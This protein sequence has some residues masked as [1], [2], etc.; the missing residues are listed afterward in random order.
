VTIGCGVDLPEPVLLELPS[1]G[2][3]VRCGS[4]HAQVF[5]PATGQG[6]PV[7]LVPGLGCGAHVYGSLARVLLDTGLLEVHAVTLAGF[8]GVPPGDPPPVLPRWCDDLARY[9]D[10]H[11]RERPVL[12]G[13]SLGA[14]V[15]LAVAIERG[16][17]IGGVVAL[18]GVPAIAGLV[19]PS[20]DLGAV[21]TD[22]LRRH[23]ELDDAG[24][25]AW[26]ASSLKGMI[27]DPDVA[28]RLTES[29]AASDPTTVRHAVAEILLADVRSQM[30]RIRAPVLAV[31]ALGP[32]KNAM[33]RGRH[34]ASFGAMFLDVADRETVVL[35]QA[36]HFVML[37]APSRVHASVI[38]FIRRRA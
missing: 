32:Y 20:I 17:A 8:A 7:V 27:T 30:R 13:H 33:L 35:E 22:H 36:R 28:I 15:V 25:R 26:W 16:D 24:H 12:V 6:R 38:D 4:I 1:G 3:Q 21:A 14:Y 18:D 29:A 11:A 19:D 10:E 5:A 9:V 31:G 2:R 37:D 23:A 34:M